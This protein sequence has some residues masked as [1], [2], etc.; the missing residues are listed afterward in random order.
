[1]L[2]HGRRVRWV[3]GA[4]GLILV[5]GVLWI[6]LHP[7][8]AKPAAPKAVSVTVVPAQVMAVPVT[9]T[10]LGAS[11]AWTSDNVVPQVTGMLTKVNF[12]EGANVKAGQVLAEIDPTQYQAALTQAQGALQRDSASLS[13]A[14]VDLARYQTLVQQDSISH[15]TLD[16]QTALVQQDEGTVK[17]DQGTVAAAALNLRWCRILSPISG[18]AGV[19][20]VDPGNVVAAS[21]GQ[22]TTTLTSGA[23]TTSTGIVIINQIDPIAVVFSIPQG[24]YQRLA[25]VSNGFRTPLKTEALSQETG[26]VIATGELQ[27]ADNKVAPSTGTVTMKARFDNPK[28]A[29]LPG[30]FVNV[31]L[32]LQTLAQA[33]TVPTA[34]ISQGPNG[35]FVY[36]VGP[37]EKA[38]I[39]VV[40]PGPAEGAI[41]VI[42]SGLNAGEKVVVDGQSSLDAGVLVREVNA[43]GSKT[44]A[45]Q[46]A[47][48]QTAPAQ[49]A[50]AQTAPAKAGGPN[51]VTQ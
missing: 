11:Q 36:V 6:F 27:I 14:R 31:S 51:T 7:K 13:A 25:A 30:Q 39:R 38:V 29:L 46:A 20:N 5:V 44:E 32:T 34:A 33:I 10:A 9:I 23:T 42:Q 1:M 12:T 50:P 17:V 35:P 21:S 8:P 40:K 47:T 19:R 16:T 24:D 49:T 3:W 41:T 26:A 45:P 48:S 4:L 43:N 2:K 37:G 18:R 15:Q 28:A 22:G